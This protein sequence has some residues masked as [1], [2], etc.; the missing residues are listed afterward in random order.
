MTDISRVVCYLM[1]H[2]LR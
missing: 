1:P 2:S